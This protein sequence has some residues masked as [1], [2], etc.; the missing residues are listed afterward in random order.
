MKKVLIVFSFI[1]LLSGCYDYVEINDLVIISGMLIDYKDNKYE[2]TSQVVENEDKTK[3][4]VYTTT[5]YST[6][7]CIYEIS[8]LSN[9]DIFTSHMKVLILTES[10][11][12]N[13][14]NYIDYFLR[15]TKSKMNFYVYYIE[16]KYKKDILNIYEDEGSSFYLKDL[17]EF[18]NKVFSSSTPLSFLDLV[19]KKVEYGI[20]PIYPNIQIIKNNEKKVIYLNGLVTFSNNKKIFLDDNNS[21]LLN[22]I[23][24]K[25]NK[26]VVTIPCDNDIFSL[27]VNSSKTKYDWKD[28][29][30]NFDISLNTKINSYNCKYDLNYPKDIDKLSKITNEYIKKSII[31]L[32]NISK[33]N[34]NDF[35]GITSYIYKHSK[36]KYEVKNIDTNINVNTKID[37]IGEI[38]K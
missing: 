24:N 22:I 6:D 9:K 14:D 17:I 11:V 2:I 12:K 23:T 25:L 35:I 10:A 27:A 7:E 36:N 34:N 32:V 19:Y 8:K 37:S 33:E 5:C 29:T 15:D 4:K 26:T 28:K 21:I 13:S 20:D 18:N 38:R 3:I 31:D 1:L 30:F 16:D